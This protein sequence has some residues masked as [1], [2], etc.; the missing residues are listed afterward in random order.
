ME[1]DKISVIIPI[2]NVQSYLEGLFKMLSEQDYPNLTIICVDDGS[3]DNS[4]ALCRKLKI[5]Y[6]CLDVVIVCEK[7]KGVSAARNLGVET[8]TSEWIVFVD[9]DDE[10]APDYVSYLYGLV[11]QFRSKMG[12]C[13]HSIQR[14]KH[15]YT[16]MAVHSGEQLITAHDFLKG[17][18]NQVQYDVSPCAKIYHKSLFKNVRYPYGKLYEDTAR[19]YRLVLGSGT[20]AYG[21]ESKY[22]YKKRSQSITTQ[23]FDKAQMDYIW[24]SKEMCSG[25][26]AYF[27]DL[28]SAAAQR[29][30]FA[31]ISV[32]SKSFNTIQSKSLRR[33][34]H[35]LANQILDHKE[36]I[37]A[38]EQAP[39]RNKMAVHIL[40]LFGVNGFRII[41]RFYSWQRQI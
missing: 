40:E 4:L 7:N 22:I 28:K 20:V 41:W 19:T 35:Q 27:P 23:N 17:L 6:Q 29:L 1:F 15:L 36:T 18:L 30:T 10:I 5:R 13:S 2:Y 8:A 11:K 37:L 14:D 21:Y 39:N 34:Q 24:A 12:A 32:L 16:T 31:Y 38:Y 26:S 3:T 33:L 9:A 25:V